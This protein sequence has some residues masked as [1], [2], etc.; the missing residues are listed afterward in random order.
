MDEVP[1]RRKFQSK[2]HNIDR[3]Q[4]IPIDPAG[5]RSVYKYAGST[6]HVNISERRVNGQTEKAIALFCMNTRV[7][8]SR[9]EREV[10]KRSGSRGMSEAIRQEDGER[11]EGEEGGE[12]E[13]EERKE[14]WTEEEK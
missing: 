9:R 3:G 10:R 12:E 6:V 11:T 7:Q 2:M 14:L 8:R 4:M 1:L 5:N 13:E